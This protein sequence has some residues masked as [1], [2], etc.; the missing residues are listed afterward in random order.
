[1]IKNISIILFIFVCTLQN[2]HA[3]SDYSIANEVKRIDISK[4]MSE[5]LDDPIF[6]KS[7][8]KK[9]S[10]FVVPKKL[11]EMDEKTFIDFTG[12]TFNKRKKMDEKVCEDENRNG[13]FIFIS[14]S[15]SVETLKNILSSSAG[16]KEITLVTR[17]LAK[18]ESFTTNTKYWA[19]YIVTN[20][21]PPNI[22]MDPALFKK[23]SI[24]RVPHMI[25]RSGDKLA[26]VAGRSN[27]EWFERYVSDNGFK[28]YGLLGT[29]Y[30]ISEKDLI[31]EFKERLSKIDFVSE[32][33]KIKSR[34]WDTMEYKHLPQAIKKEIFYIDPSMHAL[35]DITDQKGNILVKKGTIKN[36]L[37]MITLSK[38]Y[39][40]IDAQRED[41]IE[42]AL[43]LLDMEHDGA[44]PVLIMVTRF[45]NTKTKHSYAKLVR[46]FNRPIYLL[47]QPVINR[48]DLT[49]IPAL[50]TQKNHLLEVTQ[51][52]KG[53]L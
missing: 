35:K 37:D 4:E 38:R 9:N 16:K 47:N 43:D 28:D 42:F 31:E 36:P 18:G 49:G 13:K 26:Q 41:N 29:T 51:F 14:E 1:M 44:K 21:S 2:S 50:I 22:I 30:D 53:D 3:E 11:H 52:S 17:G 46:K 12:S 20:K 32:K 19:N 25:I 27:V 45:G 10:D 8:R 15:I 40:V 7:L 5:I 6:L 23:Y 48:F 33:E 24:S 39:L 34:M